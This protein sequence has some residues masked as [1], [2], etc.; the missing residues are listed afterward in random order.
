MNDV[1][2]TTPDRLGFSNDLHIL[3]DIAISNCYK[4]TVVQ[5]DRKLTE[6]LDTFH[7]ILLIRKVRHYIIEQ[8]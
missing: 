7:F 4:Y 2:L 8:M 3:S 6:K 1:H 5:T